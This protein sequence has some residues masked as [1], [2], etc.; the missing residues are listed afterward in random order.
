MLNKSANHLVS[1]LEKYYAFTEEERPVYIY[2]FELLLSTLSSI[3][4]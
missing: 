4:N 1:L 3:I 2:G